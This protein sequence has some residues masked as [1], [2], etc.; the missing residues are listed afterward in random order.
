MNREI[1]FFRSLALSKGE[2]RS[3]GSMFS[4]FS[5]KNLRIRVSHGERCLNVY[6]DGDER[7]G[8]MNFEFLSIGEGIMIIKKN[9]YSRTNIYS[10]YIYT[11]II[12]GRSTRCNDDAKER[13]RNDTYIFDDTIKIE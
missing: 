2:G 7:F 13:S 12:E 11:K 4:F 9:M 5:N 1:S 8:K 6:G 3:D 10:A